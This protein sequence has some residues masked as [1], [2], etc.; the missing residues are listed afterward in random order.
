MLPAISTACEAAQL[1]VAR[2]LPNVHAIDLSDAGLQA[3]G[4][5]LR[6]GMDGI[7]R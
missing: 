7:C 4:L 3:D 5:R 1:Q 6:R 2:E